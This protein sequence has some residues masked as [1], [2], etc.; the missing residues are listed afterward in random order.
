MQ[1]LLDDV[2]MD[3]QYVKSI[4]AQFIQNMLNIP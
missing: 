3:V 1:R 2:R 4:N